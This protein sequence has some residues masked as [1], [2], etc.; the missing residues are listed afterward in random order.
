MPDP[1]PPHDTTRMPR[2]G[3]LMFRPE[4][5]KAPAIRRAAG[6]GPPPIHE[7]KDGTPVKQAIADF[8]RTVAG[9]V[10]KNT[11]TTAQWR[12]VLTPNKIVKEETANSDGLRALAHMKSVLAK[13]LGRDPTVEEQCSIISIG[14]ILDLILV[15]VLQCAHL[16]PALLMNHMS[17]VFEAAG[18]KAFSG[19]IHED[20]VKMA[21][22]LGLFQRMDGN[23]PEELGGK[24]TDAESKARDPLT[25]LSKGDDDDTHRAKGRPEDR[26]PRE[27]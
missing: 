8:L 9:W 13:S 26:P 18:L 3:M 17:K 5:M 12:M 4:D 1:M 20:D 11:A 2:S 19:V 21:R 16:P 27:L 14:S 10:E 24:I 22:S 6:F 23:P 15:P 25:S 7:I